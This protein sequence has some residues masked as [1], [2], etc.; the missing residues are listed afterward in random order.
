L[1]AISEKC[2]TERGDVLNQAAVMLL[3][4]L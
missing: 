2:L 4:G 1:S 3:I